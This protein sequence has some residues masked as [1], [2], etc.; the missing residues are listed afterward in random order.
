MVSN[1]LLDSVMQTLHQYGVAHQCSEFYDAVL[2]TQASVEAKLSQL[3]MDRNDIIRSQYPR[4]LPTPPPSPG[5]S[6]PGPS[7]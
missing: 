3:L 7:S 6:V 1:F 5:P 2:R 4:N